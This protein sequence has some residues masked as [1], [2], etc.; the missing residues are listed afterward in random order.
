MQSPFTHPIIHWK[1]AVKFKCKRKESHTARGTNKYPARPAI[2]KHA[3]NTKTRG[4]LSSFVSV[5]ENACG[6][7]VLFIRLFLLLRRFFGTVLRKY[8]WIT[9]KFWNTEGNCSF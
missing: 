2:H 5:N 8:L 9:T 6:L 3:Q 1:F 4:V 7:D